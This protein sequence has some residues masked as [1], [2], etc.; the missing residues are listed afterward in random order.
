MHSKK[1]FTLGF[2]LL[3]LFF[4]VLFVMFMPLWNGHNAMAYLDNLYNSISKGSAYYVPDMKEE[5]AKMES[6]DVDLKVSMS[7]KSQAES[8]ASILQAAGVSTSVDEKVIH[9][10]G[11]YKDIL[12]SSL[13]DADIMYN[14]NGIDMQ[15]KYQL[16]AQKDERQALYDWHAFLY[17]LENSLSKQKRFDD[18]KIVKKIVSKVVEP[19]YNYYKIHAENIRDKWGIVF[20]SLIFYVFY[21]MWY[22]FSILFIFEG[23]GL[24]ISH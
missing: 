15:N 10:S 11:K 13:E 8:M 1:E 19:A 21:T 17:G 20:L 24:K 16:Y 12:M 22:G 6:V 4:V 14:N 23:W 3:A 18:A 9:V 7:S 2:V 5:I